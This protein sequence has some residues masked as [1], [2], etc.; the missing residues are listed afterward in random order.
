MLRTA[1]AALFLAAALSS[2]MAAEPTISV[3]DAWARATPQG[4]KTGAAYV[5]ITNKGDADTLLGASTLVAGEAQLHTTTTDNGVMKMRPLKSLGLK[6]GASVALKP[7]GMHIMLMD[8]KQPLQEGE[9]FPLALDFQK[10]G[11]I[12]TVVKVQKI[13]A[14]T[15]TSMQGMDMK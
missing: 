10:A 2:A 15:G 7:G 14:M 3:T 11:R 6:P 13:G 12:E 9:S 5:T 1:L 8:L 4:A